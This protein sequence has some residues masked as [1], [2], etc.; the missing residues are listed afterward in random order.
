[1]SLKINAPSQD[2]SSRVPVIVKSKPHCEYRH[3]GAQRVQVQRKKGIYARTEISAWWTGWNSL[4][5][6]ITRGRDRYG[7][8]NEHNVLVPRDHWLTQWEKGCYY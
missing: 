5:P 1:M 8:A 6:S 3:L 4:A 2:R 7:K